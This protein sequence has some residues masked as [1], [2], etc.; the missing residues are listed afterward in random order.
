MESEQA[1][2]RFY[3]LVWPHMSAVLRTAQILCGGNTADAED[4]AQETM[5]KAFRAMDQFQPG[6]DM[7]SW[8]FAI[9]RNARI[10][11][12]RSPASTS[13]AVSL[14]VLAA[15]PPSR[16]EP[17]RLDRST[18]EEDPAAVLNT[19]S[20]QQII[21]A[22]GKLPEEIRWTLL[23]IDVEG[24]EHQEA[25]EV[26]HVPVGTIKSRAHRGRAMLRQTLLPVAR[27]A[28]IVRDDVQQ[29]DVR[30]E[31]SSES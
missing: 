9:L 4:L 7:K 28:R 5:L 17:E 27:Q 15:E 21:E 13:S 20:D 25:A 16:P 10:D 18:I 31:Q 6:T 29:T 1:K 19:F 2:Q 24:M 26:L 11:R 23:L 22:M 3:E 14:E 12:L 30:D 8:L